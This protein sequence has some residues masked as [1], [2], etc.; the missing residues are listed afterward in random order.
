MTEYL[1]GVHTVQDIKYH[2]VWITK[3]RYK[4][5]AGKIAKRTRELL[6]QGCKSIIIEGSIGKDHVHMLIAAPTNIAPS[7]G[8]SRFK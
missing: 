4:I 1:H 8:V 5:L 7:K 2:I 6:I 3:Y